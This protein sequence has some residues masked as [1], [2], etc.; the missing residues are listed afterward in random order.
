MA[1]VAVAIVSYI[2]IYTVVNVFFRKPADAAHE[3]A[4]EARQRERDFVQATMNGW[5]RF[6]ARLAPAETGESNA[7]EAA[8]DVQ[9]EPAPA[10]LAQAVPLDLTLIFPGKPSMHPAPE[11]V[12]APAAVPAD[13]AWS[14]RLFVG[15]TATA[16]AFGETLAYAKDQHLRVFLQDE[17]R[18]TFEGAPVPAAPVM[19][20]ILPPG[21]LAP[22]FWK[23]T[24][25]TRDA[26]FTW[27][28]VVGSMPSG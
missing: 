6:A 19:K 26:I 3:P 11:Q 27:G 10:D 22:G 17:K 2:V 18:T 8:A 24:V 7:Y 4:A 25:Y 14:C 16:K 15:D 12:T 23:V 13:G 21:A 5:T 20:V 1:W 9:R 28:F